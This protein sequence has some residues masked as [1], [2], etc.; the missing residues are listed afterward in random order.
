MRGRTQER[1]SARPSPEGLRDGAATQ[2]E[3]SIPLA[4]CLR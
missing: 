2:R 4:D 3:R 1:V